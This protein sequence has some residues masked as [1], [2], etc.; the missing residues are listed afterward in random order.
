MNKEA[1]TRR[2]VDARLELMA[3]D[4]RVAMTMPHENRF[5]SAKKE[6]K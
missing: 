1:T 4:N 2:P 3:P 5:A 6:L